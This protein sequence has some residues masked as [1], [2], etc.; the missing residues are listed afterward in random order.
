MAVEQ[1]D[2]GAYL[3]RIG[4]HGPVRR[5]LDTLTA[6]HRAHLSAIPYENLDIHLG[7]WLVRGR[8]PGRPDKLM[9]HS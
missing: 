4:F 2:V 6:I 5:D 3:Q 7:R 9:F 1:M 8:L